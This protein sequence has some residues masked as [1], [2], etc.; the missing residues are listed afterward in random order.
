MSANNDRPTLREYNALG[1]LIGLA[2]FNSITVN[3]PF[4]S[5]LYRK[6]CGKRLHLND[7]MEYDPLLA[8]GLQT[9]LDFEGDVAETFGQTFVYT[10]EEF[11]VVHTKQLIE[12]GANVIVTNHNRK[13]NYIKYCQTLCA[14]MDHQNM[15]LNIYIMSSLNH[16]RNHSLR[17]RV[18]SML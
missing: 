16:V 10:W 14:N 1:M 2:A 7:L 18:A 4:S 11:G 12:N 8:R 15:S 9:L 13:G 6:L 5:A 3:L 17:F